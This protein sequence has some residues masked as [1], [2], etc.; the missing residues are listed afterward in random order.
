V[1]SKETHLAKSYMLATHTF[2]NRQFQLHE[3]P[4]E[5]DA[6]NL[7]GY[8]ME[9]AIDAIALAAIVLTLV[10][11]VHSQFSEL[12]PQIFYLAI[13]SESGQ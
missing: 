6:G 4:G 3:L 11:L 7:T 1:G 12:I 10:F 2:H 13:P 5:V 9:F 8:S